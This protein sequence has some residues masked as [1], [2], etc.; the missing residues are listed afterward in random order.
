MEPKRVQPIEGVLNFLQA[1]A[2]NNMAPQERGKINDILG[3]ITVDTCLLGDTDTW[4]TGIERPEI[5]GKWVLVE[6][7]PNREAAEKGHA[8]WVK[9]MADEPTFPLK[10]I[11]LWSLDEIE[12]GRGE[13][14]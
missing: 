12:D 6:Q 5:E 8:H 3:G 10:D 7:Y 4:E 11:N 9:L 1:M 13:T 14:C 2:S